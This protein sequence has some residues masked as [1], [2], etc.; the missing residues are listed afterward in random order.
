MYLRLVACTHISTQSLN[1][2]RREGSE[3][4]T[5]RGG[6]FYKAYIRWNKDKSKQ[7]SQTYA[8]KLALYYGKHK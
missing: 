7:L 4:F 2:Q 8:T 6:L 3:E 5:L 1:E